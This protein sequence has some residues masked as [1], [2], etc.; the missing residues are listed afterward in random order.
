MNKSIL[1]VED[2]KRV[3]E[4]INNVV[5]RYGTVEHVRAVDG[6][7]G[8]FEASE[9]FFDLVV[10]DLKVV[11]QGLTQEQMV[12]YRDMEG[13]AF[14]NEYYLRDVKDDEEIKQISKTIV[15]CSRYTADFEKRFPKQASQFTLITKNNGFIKKLESHVNKLFK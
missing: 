14:I 2:D 5:S 6:A 4:M 12:Q 10:L 8:A 9:D 1:I 3:Y 13:L 11:A 15:I 7:I